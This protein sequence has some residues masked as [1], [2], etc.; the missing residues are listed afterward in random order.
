VIIG[1]LAE[2]L[3]NFRGDLLQALVSSG[4]TVT[5]AAPAG[6][7]W[8]DDKLREWGVR[9]AVLPM[10]R[11]GISVAQD[12]TLLVSLWRLLRSERPD[13]VLGYTIKP[14]VFGSLAARLAGVPHKVAMITGLGFAFMEAVSPRQRAVQRV[15]RALYW[16]AL[17]CADVVLFQNGDD[18]RALRGFGLL[19]AG[20]DVR[21][22]AGSGVNLRRFARQPLP[23]GQCRFLLVARLLRDKGVREYFSAA[24]QVRSTHPGSECHLVGPLDSNPSA[25][26]EQELQEAVARGD[27]VYHG[28]VDDVRP[29]LRDCHVYVLPSYREGMPRSVLEAMATGRPIITT[30]APGCRET[31]EPGLNGVLVPVGDAQALAEAMGHYAGLDAAT[32]EAQAASSRRLA[33]Q[34]FAVE[35]VNTEILDALGVTAVSAEG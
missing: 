25:V 31:V 16:L 18:E 34:R 22:I 29:F 13:A 4:C 24:A 20:A 26:T 15:A 9:R 2:S 3:V 8:V 33:E 19:P 6:P 1:S 7:A 14:V 23:S 27:V 5:A 35:Q 32:L 12:L 10:N 30:D 11:T 28:A 17:R 21:R